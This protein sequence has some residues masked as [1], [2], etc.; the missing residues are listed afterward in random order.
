MS[1]LAGGIH[2]LKG[3]QKPMSRIIPI[4]LS[5]AVLS[6]S[7][8]RVFAE[9]GAKTATGHTPPA[10]NTSIESLKGKPKTTLKV[11]K[12]DMVMYVGDLHCKHCAK[13]LTG[14]LYTVKGVKTVRADIKAD[15][16]VI[17]PQNEEKPRSQGSLGWPP[18]SP[19]SRPS[20]SSAPKA[21]TSWTRR[22][23]SPS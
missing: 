8:S 18:R 14:K 1:E 22:P 20:S 11:A 12:T 15:V 6:V 16:A 19:A 17:T 5:V 21:R 10:Q 9:S 3:N 4:A 13:S 2:F 7:T 23:K